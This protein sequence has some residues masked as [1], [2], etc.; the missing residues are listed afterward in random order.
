M[1]DAQVIIA[2]NWK[3]LKANVALFLQQKSETLSVQTKRYILIFFCLL[4]GGGSVA[5]VIHSSIGKQQKIS[6]IAISKPIYSTQTGDSYLKSDSS[7]TKR[8]YDKVEQFKSYLLQLKND[9]LRNN[10]FESIIH[11]RPQLMD[12][13]HLFEKLYLQQK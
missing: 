5:I 8:E 6:L 1:S 13:I 2:N 3:V 10:E 12:S 9:S 4:F 11:T 7:I